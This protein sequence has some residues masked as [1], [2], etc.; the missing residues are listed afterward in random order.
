MPQLWTCSENS[1]VV[2]LVNLGN[3]V[4]SGSP[5]LNVLNLLKLCLFIKQRGLSFPLI[6]SF[7]LYKK[8]YRKKRR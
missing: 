1:N 6:L 4:Y 8:K 7:L 3:V 5:I 2:I